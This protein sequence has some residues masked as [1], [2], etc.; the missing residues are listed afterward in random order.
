[1]ERTNVKQQ[2][3]GSVVKPKVEVIPP[4]ELENLTR[5]SPDEVVRDT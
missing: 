1:M 4:E 5:Q 2:V 3:K